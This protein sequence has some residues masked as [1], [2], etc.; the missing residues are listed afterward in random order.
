MADVSYD[1]GFGQ[2]SQGRDFFHRQDAKR[3]L[4]FEK[5]SQAL[6]RAIEDDI[7]PQLVK[8]HRAG[9]GIERLRDIHKEDL[10]RRVREFAEFVLGQNA[11]N[12]GAHVQALREQGIPLEAIYLQLIAPT[13]RYLKQLW[14]DDKRDFAAIS[15]GFWRLQQLL[16]DF[17][18]AFRDEAQK[19]AGMRALL[20]PAPGESNDVGYLMFGLVM[21]GE[22]FRRDGCDTWIEP[23]SG[24]EQ[25]SNL[26]RSEWFDVVE[27]LVSSEKRLDALA[28]K[29]KTVRNE[30]LNRA[31]GV[32]VCGP[33]FVEHPELVL[34]VGGDLPAA[35]PRD[36]VAQARTLLGSPRPK[37]AGKLQK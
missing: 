19:A 18:A 1:P 23:E 9:Q 10:D 35:D 36:G 4:R 22:F 14:Q 26:I 13:A 5:P 17:S 25:V 30:S 31:L 32:V 12:A 3:T 34:L 24:S 29:I 6:Q 16:R 11:D 28:A 37:T 15:L 20:M 2:R 27:F 8:A 21:L 7:V 33:M